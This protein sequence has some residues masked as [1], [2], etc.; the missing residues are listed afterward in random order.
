MRR[1]R[2][3]DSLNGPVVSARTSTGRTLTD[4]LPDMDGYLLT[5]R[6]WKRLPGRGALLQMNCMR[7]WSHGLEDEAGDRIAR[8]VRGL[9]REVDL[10]GRC[11]CRHLGCSGRY[12]QELE[13]RT[14]VGYA[15]DR[16]DQ[17][18]QQGS[19]DVEPEFLTHGG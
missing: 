5:W 11:T 12:T 19:L 18:V 3:L 8:V 14:V 9:D 7:A 2:L 6:G 4:G 1:H 13:P 17:V 10:S 16:S 15:G